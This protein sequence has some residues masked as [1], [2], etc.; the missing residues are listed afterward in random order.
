M[1]SEFGAK[2]SEAIGCRL[3]CVDVA[4]V[5]VNMGFRCNQQCAHCHLQAGPDRD[6]QM[7]GRTVDD[8]LRALERLGRPT[9]DITGG[10][11]ELNPEFGRLVQEG[12]EAGCAVMVRT[13]LTA[14]LERPDLPS[15]L[16]EREATVIASMPCYLPENVER[17]RGADVYGKSITALKNLNDLGYGSAPRLELN[18]VYNPGG[19]FLPPPQEDLERDYKQHLGEEFGIQFN[20]LFAFTN[21]AVGRFA[22]GLEL[23]GELE[24]YRRMLRRSFNAA[25]IESL[26]CRHQISVGPDGTLYDC[27]FNLA[28]GMLVSNRGCRHVR[29][30]TPESLIGREIV[31]DEHCFACTAGAGSSCTGVLASA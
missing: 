3:A 31:T 20:H 18:L 5:Q 24:E 29:D 27:D 13:N 25:T 30:M 14:L 10:A 21:V 2:V 7:S 17:Q 12:R 4:T 19:P 16:A 6:N 15:F 8:V 11:P 9:L 23:G 1:A 26:M 22:E 28:L